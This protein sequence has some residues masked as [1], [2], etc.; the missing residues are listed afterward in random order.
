MSYFEE[1]FVPLGV[2]WCSPLAITEVMVHMAKQYENGSG[3][4]KLIH[5][6]IRSVHKSI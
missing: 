2:K 3:N 6:A 5:S 1:N 4:D